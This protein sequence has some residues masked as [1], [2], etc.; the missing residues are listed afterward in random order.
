MNILDERVDILSPPLFKPNG[1]IKTRK[2][3]YIDGDW[4]GVFNLWIVTKDPIPSI[5]YQQ[6]SPETAWAPNML[7]VTAGGHFLAGEEICDGLREVEEEL[8]KQYLMKDLIP[9]GKKLFVG[10]NTDGTSRNNLNN[11]YATEDNTSLKSYRLS[12]SEVYAICKCP[13]EDLLKVHVDSSYKF[14]AEAIDVNSKEFTL[15]INQKSFPENWDNY[16]YKIAILMDRYFKGDSD[17]LY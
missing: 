15:C 7:D 4:T 1:K 2:Q 14:E 13:I 17:L 6:R 9:L 16:H 8:G 5:I 12:P 11:I 10:F 3:A